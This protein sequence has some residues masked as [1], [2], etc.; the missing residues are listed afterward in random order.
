MKRRYKRIL[1]WDKNQNHKN[2]KR[3][4]KWIVAL[5]IVVG[6]ITGFC[7]WFFV[8]RCGGEH[9][10]YNYFP[11]GEMLGSTLFFWVLPYVIFSGKK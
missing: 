7:F 4:P 1:E 5:S 8:T 2:D 10:F 11:L 3:P 9:C 6:L